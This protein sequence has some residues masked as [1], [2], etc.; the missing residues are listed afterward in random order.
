MSFFSVLPKFLNW[1][2]LLGTLGDALIQNFF[3]MCKKAI[4][5]L[6]HV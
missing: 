2:T 1:E 4:Q 5:S 3:P 6:F